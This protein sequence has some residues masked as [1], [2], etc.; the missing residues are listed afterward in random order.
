M[1]A[2]DAN[3]ARGRLKSYNLAD[4]GQL[5]QCTKVAPGLAPL[6]ARRNAAAR[7]RVARRN[8]PFGTADILT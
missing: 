6:S 1:A 8:P 3:A 7:A 4:F 5:S 2:H